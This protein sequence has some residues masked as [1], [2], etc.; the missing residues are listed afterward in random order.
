MPKK[1][2]NYN[3]ERKKILLDIFNIIGITEQNNT[4][5]LHTM[6]SD[7][8]K[9]NKI[10]ELEQEIKRYFICSEWSCIKNKEKVKRRW[11]SLIKYISK[12]NGYQIFPCKKNVTI[13]DKFV[14]DTI[15]HLIKK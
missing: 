12:N 8:E 5:S 2:D 9:Q 11:L 13:N 10:Y 7:V 14:H 1:V 15:Y 3:E 6:D 4:F